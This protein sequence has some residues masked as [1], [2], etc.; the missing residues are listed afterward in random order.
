MRHLKNVVSSVAVAALLVLL[1]G[2]SGGSGEK[3]G[4]TQQAEIRTWAE[5]KAAAVDYSRVA[6]LATFA[7]V[8]DCKLVV[9]DGHGIFTTSPQITKAMFPAEEP[10]N[11]A[12][13][14]TVLEIAG[15]DVSAGA[16]LPTAHVQLAD[17]QT[18]AMTV[19]LEDSALH[20]HAEFH[21]SA[22]VT[23]SWPW[24]NGDA[25]FD[26]ITAD[27]RIT[28]DTTGRFVA[29]KDSLQ[30]ATGHHVE[31]C[32]ALGWCDGVANHALPDLGNIIRDSFVDQMNAELAKQGTQ[33]MILS[34][35]KAGVNFDLKPGEA[36]WKIEAGSA[37]ISASAIH[38][39]VTRGTTS[40]VWEAPGDCYNGG[41]ATG[42]ESGA[43][44]M[45]RDFAWAFTHPLRCNPDGLPTLTYDAPFP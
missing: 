18:D 30:V 5:N 19:E 25:I 11:P 17:L 38:V 40:C 39:N 26:W 13:H 24:P 8:G 15:V 36:P 6:L 42:G 27:V 10:P 22:H 21:G 23:T 4:S 29:V 33:D 37:R 44:A 43:T 3:S 45:C 9:T 14:A 12:A 31:N 16:F 35:V 2:C 34:F 20:V 1:S 7:H 32:G 41:T 28:A